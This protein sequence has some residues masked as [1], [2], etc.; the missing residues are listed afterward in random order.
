MGDAR[1][2]C[3]VLFFNWQKKDPRV[4]VFGWLR[5]VVIMAP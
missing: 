3:N 5:D 2:L 4:R 1:P